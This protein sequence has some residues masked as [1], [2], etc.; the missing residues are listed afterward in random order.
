MGCF[1]FSTKVMTTGEGG[2]IVT[3]IKKF[4]KKLNHL[5]I[6]EDQKKILDKKN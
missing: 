6:L 5:K 3:K 4:M 2:M 1:S